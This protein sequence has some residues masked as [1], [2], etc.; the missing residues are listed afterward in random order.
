MTEEKRLEYSKMITKKVCSC[1]Q[2]LKA[3]NLLV[4]ISYKSEVN[5]YDI[6]SEAFKKG[7]KVFCPKVL[8]PGKMEFYEIKSFEDIVLG[9]KNIPEPF[10]MEIL[11]KNAE[12]KKTLMIMPL[13][14]F[15]YKGNRL[16]YGGGFYDRYLEKNPE[17]KKIALAFECQ[18]YEK[19]LPVEK[20]D[21]KPEVIFTEKL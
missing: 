6:I 18:R 4:Y 17:V 11:Y 12:E 9:Y 3:D 5:T 13:V 2:Y 21:I 14:S 19:E 20:T 16:G 15:D 8:E 10:N 1:E 7:K